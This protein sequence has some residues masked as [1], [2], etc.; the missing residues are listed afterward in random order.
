MSVGTS[1]RKLMEISIGLD[2]KLTGLQQDMHHTQFLLGKI[3]RNEPLTVAD[4][5]FERITQYIPCNNYRELQKLE[6]KLESSDAFLQ[7]A[8]SVINFCICEFV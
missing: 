7:H 5:E 4:L 8:V 6:E 2:Q 1:L 3:V